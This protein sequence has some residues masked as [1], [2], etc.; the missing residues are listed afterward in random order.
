MAKNNFPTT[1]LSFV[2]LVMRADAETLR[3]ALEAREK[4][5]TLLEEREKAYRRIAELEGQVEE[6][7]GAPGAF[8]F[9]M[10][11]VPVA[12]YGKIAVAHPAEKKEQ[13]ASKSAA[14][15]AK[16]GSGSS[17]PLAN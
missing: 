16:E 11:P 10:P 15:S 13:P 12:G 7:V 5:D 9:P 3:Q 8:V 17:E 14:A 4:I 1:P 2:E 6:I